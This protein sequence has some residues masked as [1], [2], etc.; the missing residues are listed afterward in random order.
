V[1]RIRDFDGTIFYTTLIISIDYEALSIT[2]NKTLKH[3]LICQNV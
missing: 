2:Y 3:T 1:V